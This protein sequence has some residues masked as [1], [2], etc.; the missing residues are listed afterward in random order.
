VLGQV[1]VAPDLAERYFPAQSPAND[2]LTEFLAR[3]NPEIGPMTYA[4]SDDGLGPLHELHVPQNL[5]QLLIASMSSEM[6]AT[7][8][9]RNETTARAILRTLVAAESTY[10]EVKGGGRYGTLD[11]LVAENL[12]DKNMFD[13]FGYR[14]EL[15]ASGTK[16]EATAVP[17]E[18]G[19]SG[20]LSYFIDES[21]VLR[22][23]D[24]GGGAATSAD[25]Q[26][27]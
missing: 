21:G 2:K 22:G 3:L 27:P 26:I 12:V 16:F 24:R 13:K 19:K 9:A 15:N 6:S 5:L 10:R 4:L 17:V 25:N 14:V 7:P 18:Y 1:Y 11:E 8:M 20:K 23:G